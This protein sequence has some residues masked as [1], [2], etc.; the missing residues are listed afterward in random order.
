MTIE[1]YHTYLSKTDLI[2][3]YILLLTQYKDA[4]LFSWLDLC[5]EK[6]HN[7][8]AQEVVH[9]VYENG[10]VRGFMVVFETRGVE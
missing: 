2:S 7:R 8:K 10:T 3:L 5:I 9:I 1:L 4:N 6:S